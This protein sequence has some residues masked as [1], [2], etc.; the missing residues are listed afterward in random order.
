MYLTRALLNPRRQG[1]TALL[2]NPQRLHAAI[3]MGFPTSPTDRILWRLDTDDPRRPIL[4]LTSKDRPDLT[5]LIE[6]AGWPT[7]DA[8]GFESKD[9]RP[10]LDHLAAG[11]QYAFR[12]TATPTRWTR[13][14]PGAA[15]GK[16][17]AH[18]T[19]EHQI[20]WLLNRADRAGFRILD[21]KTEIPGNDGTPALQLRLRSRDKTVF[22]KGDAQDRT[23][24]TLTRI[25]YE[26]ALLVTNPDA[27]RTTLTEGIGRARAY[28]CGLLT[29]APATN[30]HRPQR[31]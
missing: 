27:L 4:W 14:K 16:L 21:T 8:T 20:H 9:Y 18:T 31:S 13:P 3:L 19:V 11:Q 6:Q 15:R 5:H 30:N 1:A 23:R 12:L 28:G 24:V 26:G 2:G 17:V 25:A 10:L 22:H 7:A 29:L